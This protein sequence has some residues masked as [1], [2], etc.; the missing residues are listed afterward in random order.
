MLL[1]LPLFF[2]SWISI[3]F[4]FFFLAKDGQIFDFKR[5]ESWSVLF[6]ITEQ[7]LLL[8][9]MENRDLGLAL[10]LCKSLNWR[11]N[12]LGVLSSRGRMSECTYVFEA[13]VSILQRNS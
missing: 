7:F 6:Y 12:S 2:L 4:P 8:E 10:R 3:R 9:K 11:W 13:G 5:F 1:L